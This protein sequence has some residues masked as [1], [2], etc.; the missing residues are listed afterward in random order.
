M[1]AVSAALRRAAEE[2]LLPRGSAILLAV[3]GGAD[4]M[5]LLHGAA[6]IAEDTGWTLSVGHVHH[7]WRAREADR[8]LAF[9]A[10]HARRLGLPSYSLRRDAK[11]V[12]RELGLSPEAGA[13][14]VRYA[15]LSEM[16]R[17]AGASLIATA[18]QQD[19]V[20]ESHVLAQERGG[21]IA[22]LAGP[23]EA[24]ADGVVRPLLGVAREDI[25]RFL[26]ERGIAFRRD[27]SNGNLRLSRNRVRRRL[28]ALRKSPGGRAAVRAIG[29]EIARLGAQRLELE[30]EFEGR[31]R[32]A[33]RTLPGGVGVDAALLAGCSAELQRLALA[34]LA[35]PFARPGRPP[36]TGRERERLLLL[37]AC[38]A[39]FRFEAGRR[40]RFERRRETL[41]VGLR[42]SEPVY[43]PSGKI[44]T[45]TGI[46]EVVP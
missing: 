11:A 26:D 23:R 22:S 46:R 42:D 31:V 27:A 41:L 12:A 37:L 9:V 21:G 24:R 14:H 20:V 2:G 19:D 40:I 6:A 33:V 3:S 36:M 15:A 5:A 10:E 28:A 17:E 25:L 35:A 34:R 43:D 44:S 29:A 8:D 13:R 4:S 1:D 45:E 32:P 16:A 39:D 7:G 18:H 30:S 38:G